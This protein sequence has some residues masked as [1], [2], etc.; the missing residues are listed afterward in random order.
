MPAELTP[1]AG[2][3][4]LSV[5]S[6]KKEPGSEDAPPAKRIKTEPGGQLPDALLVSEASSSA[7]APA[8]ASGAP[9]AASGAPAQLPKAQQPVVPEE[10]QIEVKNQ[11][12]GDARAYAKLDAHEH[13]ISSMELLNA[14]VQENTAALY[15]ICEAKVL[16]RVANCL[17]QICKD[18]NIRAEREHLVIAGMDQARSCVV[19]G[20]LKKGSFMNYVC[21]MDKF[22]L[23]IDLATLL[24]ILGPFKDSDCVAF[25]L[26]REGDDVVKVQGYHTYKRNNEFSFLKVR[27]M[28]TPQQPIGCL[29]AD[30]DGPPWCRLA[31]SSMEFAELFRDF[32]EVA[33]KFV[34]VRYTTDGAF[35]V[36]VPEAPDD[37]N[38]QVQGK[39]TIREGGYTKM[40]QAPEGEDYAARIHADYISRFGPTG[41]QICPQV[42]LCMAAAFPFTIQYRAKDLTFSVYLMPH[43]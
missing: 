18:C 8:Q 42:T 16:K 32:K 33:G 19:E 11:P 36:S 6:V 37:P 23:G 21:K 10:D 39:S 12:A 28:E 38:L 3:A 13:I 24:K 20:K 9:A 29:D 14:H 35:V 25:C 15:F 7:A 41:A 22:S 34:D 5:N 30:V 17:A 43:V 2:M 4:N 31:M 40:L 27:L 26:Q 1:T